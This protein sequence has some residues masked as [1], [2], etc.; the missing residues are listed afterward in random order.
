MVRMGWVIELNADHIDRYRKLHENAWPGVLSMITRCNIKNYTIYLRE[1]ENLLFA[2]FEYHGKDY[3]AD[4]ALM[5]QDSVTQEWWSLTDP[6]QTPLK[7][8]K[9]G[10]NWAP[11]TEV[12]HH[13]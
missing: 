13:D 1:P 11:M 12:F 5:A 6:C 10:E 9:T 8:A 3:E 7:S 4:M 2:S